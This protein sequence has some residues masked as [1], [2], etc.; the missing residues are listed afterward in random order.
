MGGR[1]GLSYTM[2]G[3]I[4]II[5]AANA[6]NPLEQKEKNSVVKKNLWRRSQVLLHTIGFIFF[7]TLM[8]MIS[9]TSFYKAD[10]S[11]Y[12]L[13]MK[14][15]GAGLLT[16]LDQAI[17]D[18]LSTAPYRM[19][20]ETIIKTMSMGTVAFTQFMINYIMLVVFA[21]G[22]QLSSPLVVSLMH[23]IEEHFIKYAGLIKKLQNF[24]AVDDDEGE[25][26]QRM[27]AEPNDLT[28]LTRIIDH[29]YQNSTATVSQMFTIPVAL[30]V[31][32]FSNL[33]KVESMYGQKDLF[34]TIV[35]G[36]VIFVF[37]VVVDAFVEN[38]LE[39]AFAMKIHKYLKDM[40]NKF[41]R[42]RKRW[43]LDEKFEDVD[44][45]WG[46]ENEPTAH[47]FRA[48]QSPFLKIHQMCFSEQFYFLVSL[49]TLG[50][51]ITVYAMYMLYSSLEDRPRY[52]PFDDFPLG[53]FIIVFVLVLCS[54]VK[55]VIFKLGQYS[56]TWGLKGN[57][58]KVW[59]KPFIEEIISDEDTSFDAALVQQNSEQTKK[60]KKKI[61]KGRKAPH[62]EIGSI[63]KGEVSFEEE[64]LLGPQDSLV[65]TEFDDKLQ[66]L[67]FA[68]IDTPHS[69]LDKME[70]LVNKTIRLN[71]SRVQG[72]KME[73]TRN[74]ILA[75]QKTLAFENNEV[76]AKRRGKTA[77][78]DFEVNMAR[79]GVRNSSTS[80]FVAVSRWPPELAMKHNL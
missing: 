58:K 50:Q 49:V 26:N 39:F 45:E 10:V 67:F 46:D 25:K 7:Q 11:M 21:S 51:I 2:L 65:P 27:K 55:V 80:A 43:I 23:K 69:L 75:S 34:I 79:I 66:H 16:Y 68:E 70:S 57:R 9:R 14:V 77:T 38:I 19:C 48:E 31:I 41:Y 73:W 53:V 62:S 40:R 36:I 29:Q 72:R 78:P 71:N 20:Q 63:Q 24:W 8:I 74:Y 4:I 64:M 33:L 12:S 76:L 13:I 54:M 17:P 3:V 32:L 42:R 44:P 28:K 61:S 15:S 35:F 30:L 1:M 56:G 6:T 52:Y 18:R 5:K 37:Q 22:A 60:N 47:Q 59:T